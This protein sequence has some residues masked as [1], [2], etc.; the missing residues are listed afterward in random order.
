MR[1]EI[2]RSRCS[3][4]RKQRKQGGEF[5]PDR[6]VKSSSKGRAR[7][8]DSQLMATLLPSRAFQKLPSSF[9]PF[10]FYVVLDQRSQP[11]F[12]TYLDNA[13]LKGVSHFSESPPRPNPRNTAKS[14]EKPR[15]FSFVKALSMALTYRP[16]VSCLQRNNTTFQ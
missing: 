11:F 4:R 14:H 12:P 16:R 7:A 10:L 6:D 2:R 3:R 1:R 8:S 9:F 15:P 13:L 5:I